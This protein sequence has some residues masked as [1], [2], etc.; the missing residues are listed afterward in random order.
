[1]EAVR[2]QLI[3]ERIIGMVSLQ[4]E[5]WEVVLLWERVVVFEKKKRIKNHVQ[6]VEDTELGSSPL[7]VLVLTPKA[8]QARSRVNSH[9][10]LPSEPLWI[11]TERCCPGFGDSF[12]GEGVPN[13]QSAPAHN[14]GTG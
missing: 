14:A 7:L 12:K 1:M 10:A 2:A 5:H 11:Q 6:N 8:G 13:P 3:H 9:T 4:R